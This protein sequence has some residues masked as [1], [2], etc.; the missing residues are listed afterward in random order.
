MAGNDRRAAC[1]RWWLVCC[2]FLGLTAAAEPALVVNG[3]T[4]AGNTTTLVSGSSYAPGPAFAQAL[5]AGFFADAQRTVATL[6]LGGR[7]LLVPIAANQGA[8]AAGG[9]ELDGRA[10]AGAAA[11][12]D[13][14]EIFLPVKPVAEALGGRVAYLAGQDSVVVVLPRARLTFLQRQ[15]AGGQERL[16]LNL[17]APVRYSSFYNEPVNRLDLHLERTDLPK[18]LQGVDGSGFVRAAPTASGGSVDV[19][20][21]LQPDVRYQLYEVPSGAGFQLIVAF[22]SGEPV[23]P[24]G[25]TRRVVIDPGHGGEDV[26]LRFPGQ[27]TEASLTL[28]FAQRLQ[29]ALEARGI[30][31]ELT[32]SRDLDVPAN[33]RARDGVASDL[34]LSVH[35]AA[36]A[37]GSFHAYYLADADDI[38]GLSMAIR[39]NAAAAL[40]EEATDSVRRQVL[41]DLVPDLDVGRRYAEGIAGRLFESLALRSSDTSG[42]PLYVLTGAAG[43]GVLLEFGPDDLVASELPEALAAAVVGLLESETP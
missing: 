3:L 30:Q 19:R 7:T 18:T 41:L 38:E 21:Q 23:A 25:P 16:V 17:S 10:V 20:I 40:G 39:T 32:R 5:G 9:L 42:A 6:T 11:V 28:Q 12:F 15:A 26:G 34:F 29:T 31:V 22:Y 37:P 27:G 24:T 13:S 14:G 43:R 1:L 33:T 2:C 8:A 4:V 35:A 36:L